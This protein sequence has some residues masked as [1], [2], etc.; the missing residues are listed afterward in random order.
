MEAKP[1]GQIQSNFGHNRITEITEMIIN[2]IQTFI[3][4][5]YQKS[6]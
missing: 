4:R 3:W 2:S 6:G 1:P 5:K